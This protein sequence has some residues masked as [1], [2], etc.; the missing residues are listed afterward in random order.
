MS[1][2]P[3]IPPGMPPGIPPV[4]SSE[5]SSIKSWER[6]VSLVVSSVLTIFFIIFYFSVWRVPDNSAE[7]K[8]ICDIT[9]E[10]IKKAN[11]IP[12]EE[13]GWFPFYEA[14]EKLKTYRD[15]RISQYKTDPSIIGEHGL[16][17]ENREIMRKYIADNGEVL[18][19]CEKSHG[20]KSFHFPHDYEKGPNEKLPDFRSLRYLRD[21]LL[22]SGDIAAKE[23]RYRDAAVLYMNIFRPA[24]SMGKDSP[25]MMGLMSNSLLNVTLARLRIFINNYDPDADTCRFIIKE[26]SR[27]EKERFPYTDLMDRSIL[28]YHYGIKLL[29]EGKTIG[30]ESYEKAKYLALFLDREERICENFYLKDRRT[31]SLKY[32]EACDAFSKDLNYS[33]APISLTVLNE[34]PEHRRCFEFH[35]SIDSKYGGVLLAAALKLYKSEKGRYPETL[36]ELGPEYLPKLPEDPLAGDGKYIYRNKQGKPILYS[37]GSNLKDDGGSDKPVNEF[38]DDGIDLIF[39]N[40][41]MKF[42]RKTY[43]KEEE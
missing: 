18:A 27:W 40:P 5:K 19:L 42:T 10:N 11:D 29:K 15:D 21:F 36:S 6:T 35:N 28:K 33:A 2:S 38:S 4:M 22:L 32:G 12:R 23:G 9:V 20:M 26:M 3:A 30:N 34:Y 31:A 25:T 43:D 14:A 7:V 13:N 41:G 39:L 16:T 1:D 8:R 17:K 24:I 37:T